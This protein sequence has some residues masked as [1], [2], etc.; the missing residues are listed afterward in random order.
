MKTTTSTATAVLGLAL[1]AVPLQ[2][3]ADPVADFYAN[4][5]VTVAVGHFHPGFGESLK[6]LGDAFIKLIKMPD[7]GTTAIL[8]GKKRFSLLKVTAEDPYFK[9][10][11][12]VIEEEVIKDDQPFD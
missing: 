11:V 12:T 1:A 6:P 9:G 10:E 4:R 7:G 5:T 8:Q 2:A 3:I